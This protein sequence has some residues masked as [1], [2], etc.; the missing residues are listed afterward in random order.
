MFDKFEDS[1]SP[2]IGRTAHFRWSAKGFGFGELYFYVD[3][4][5]GYVHCDNELMGR[6]FI[7]DMLCHMVDNC[8]LT[9]PGSYDKTGGLPPNYVPRPVLEENDE[10]NWMEITDDSDS[11]QG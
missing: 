8:V 9:C 3:K 6:E 7:K 11:S 2:D 10:E 5:D 1:C 4:K